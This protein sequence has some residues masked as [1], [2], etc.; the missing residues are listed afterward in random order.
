MARAS[1]KTGRNRRKEPGGEPAADEPSPSLLRARRVGLVVVL[2][3]FA[4]G[5]WVASWL[6]E[7]DRQVVSRFEGRRFSVPSR[8]YAAP[9]VIYPGVDWQRLD[10]AGWLA[11]MGYREQ[12][13]AG[14]LIVGHFRWLPGRLRV[15]LRGFEHPQLPEPNRKVEF[16]LEQGRVSEI[17]DDRGEALSV[18]ALEPEPISA[19]YGSNREQRDLI[20]IETVPEHLVA[21]I[22]SIEDRRFEEHH[23]IDPRRIVGA[24]LANLRAGGIREGGST[25]TQQFVKN[26]F[27]TPD[28]TLQR[29]LTEALMALIVEARYAKP[30]ILEAYLNE[31]YMGRRG[32]T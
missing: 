18:V 6:L 25:L 26:F 12:R 29:K 1:K 16:R 32:S 7:L 24:L 30:Q 8:V 17:S 20:E 21:A 27:L 31:I 9:L 11:R 10:L 4:A 23:G 28:R 5:L 3:A 19:F 13:E 22:Y 2:L 15:H 14:P